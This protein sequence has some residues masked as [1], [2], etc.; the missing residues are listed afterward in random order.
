MVI[1]TAGTVVSGVAVTGSIEIRASHVTVKDSNVSS[2]GA[3]GHDIYIAPGVGDVLIED[4][5]LHGADATARA[6]QYA[7]QNSG[8]SSNEGVGLSMYN[9]TTCWAGPGT[10]KD[11]YAISN[12]T[13]TGAHYE[14]LYYGGGGG[15][16]TVEHDTLLN[17]HDQTADVF[18]S[19]DFGDQ[20]AL[21]ITANLMAGGGYMIYGGASGGHGTVLGPVAVT[22]N[23]FARCRTAVIPDHAGGGYHCRDGADT[24][25]YWPN[26]GHYGVAGSFDERATIW[27]DNT[28]DGTG[29]PVPFPG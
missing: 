1:G 16:L 17:P 26:G 24:H 9:C 27:S 28:W 23:R 2:Y 11:S 14:P 6:I 8:A 25:G 13:V 7:V 15:P 18:A 21:T 22:D 4:S 5:T 12:A 19:V 20:T 3:T 10:L 29:V